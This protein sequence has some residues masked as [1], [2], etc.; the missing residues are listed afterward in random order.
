MGNKLFYLAL[1]IVGVYIYFWFAEKEEQ[2]KERLLEA[3]IEL[4]LRQLSSDELL[5]YCD[6]E[7]KNL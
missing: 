6:N 5:F 7:I 4:N 1:C 2:R 3:C